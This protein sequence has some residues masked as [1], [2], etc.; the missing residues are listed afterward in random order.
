M[1][2]S[3]AAAGT[4]KGPVTGVRAPHGARLAACIAVLMCAVVAQARAGDR[5]VIETG[6][7]KTRDLD[8]ATAHGAKVLLRRVTAMADDLCTSTSPPEHA[9]QTVWRECVAKAVA[10]TIAPIK[11][12]LVT[13]EYG[14]VFGEPRP[15]VSSR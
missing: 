12:P 9:A 4:S 14:R 2:L 10:R 7:V 11:A 8:L 6:A 13:A 1:W 5:I 3:S 15:A